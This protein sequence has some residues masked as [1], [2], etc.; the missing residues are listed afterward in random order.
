MAKISQEPCNPLVQLLQE[1]REDP[2]LC[3]KDHWKGGNSFAYDDGVASNAP[4]GMAALASQWKVESLDDLPYRTAELINVCA[5]IAGTAQRPNK[6]VKIDFIFVHFINAS[7][8]FSAFFQKE[9][10]EPAV[11]IRILEWY[12]RVILM[13]YAAS[14]GPELLIDEVVNYQPREPGST[15]SSIIRR[16]LVVPDDGH[17]PKLIRALAHGEKL[18]QPSESEDAQTALS[19]FPVKGNMWL[20][21]ANMAIDSAEIEPDLLRRWVRG[22][23]SDEAWAE[24][25]DRDGQAGG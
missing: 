9:W 19:L 1:I 14:L 7:I 12:A 11:K 22:A 23:G 10:I 15:W 13:F 2:V 25:P 6:I 4:P 17:L 16:C 18:C 20:Q 5:F 21:I 24:F 3:D 8:F